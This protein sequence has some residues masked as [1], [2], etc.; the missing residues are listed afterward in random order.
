V[1]ARE[2]AKQHPEKVRQ[3]ISLGS[4]ISSDRNYSSARHLFEAIN[5]T[6]TTP[7]VEGRYRLI[8]EA[9]PVPTTSI[10]TRS[11]GVVA[12]QGSV[13]RAQGG[14]DRVENIVVPASHIGLGVNPVVMV[15]IADRLAQPE[16]KWERFDVSG[17][18]RFVFRSY[19]E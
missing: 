6:E 19:D 2:L 3:V 1:F 7:E 9:P 17:W 16:G 12:W 10:F 18:R 11:D 14:H 13:Q 4:P 5:G 15:A 8:H